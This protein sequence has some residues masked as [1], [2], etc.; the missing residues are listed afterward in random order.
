MS[1]LTQKIERAVKSPFFDQTGRSGSSSSHCTILKL[2]LEGTCSFDCAYCGVCAKKNGISFTPRELARGF[3][4][5]HNDGRVGGLLLSTGIPRGDVDLG[6]EN[7]IET[8]PG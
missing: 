3:L 1:E 5:L 7:L 4:A 2:L 8:A 6:M